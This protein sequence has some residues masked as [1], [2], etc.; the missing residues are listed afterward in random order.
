MQ[1][2]RDIF[3]PGQKNAG[4]N[5]VLAAFQVVVVLLSML[6][7]FLFFSQF[8]GSLGSFLSN[9]TYQA[10]ASG[11]IGVILL[12][13][14]ALA[15]LKTSHRDGEQTPEQITLARLTATILLALSVGS[16]LAYLMLTTSFVK[17]AR[18][19]GYVDVAGL[20]IAAGALGLNFTSAFLYAAWSPNARRKH[21]TAV[22]G[23]MLTEEVYSATARR[24]LENRERLVNQVIEA[25]VPVIERGFL[26]AMTAGSAVVGD[27]ANGKTRANGRTFAREVEEVPF[28]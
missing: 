23:A 8:V 27:Q 17:D 11:L 2:A 7:S 13:A 4:Q 22:T 24:L 15:W 1:D 6:T 18:L 9:P 12:D 21:M 28:E 20:V 5:L 19:L 14:G 25:N 16:S 26:S 10:L 3:N